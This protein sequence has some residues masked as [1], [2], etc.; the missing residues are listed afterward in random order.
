MRPPG[1]GEPYRPA[2]AMRRCRIGLVSPPNLPSTTTPTGPGS[3]PPRAS[4]P[5][6]ILGPARLG[7]RLASLDRSISLSG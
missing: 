2:T 5:A 1:L 3:P 6:A 4:R 7:G